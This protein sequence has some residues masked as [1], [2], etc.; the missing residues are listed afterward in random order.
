MLSDVREWLAEKPLVEYDGASGSGIEV[1]KTD[2]SLAGFLLKAAIENLYA[3]RMIDVLIDEAAD[4]WSQ[5]MMPSELELYPNPI[6]SE[7][8]RYQL[9]KRCPA[10]TNGIS[11]DVLNQLIE[12][13]RLR[14]KSEGIK[15]NTGLVAGT[16][17]RDRFNKRFET[18]R[19]PD[20]PTTL[21]SETRNPN[22]IPF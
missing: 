19:L 15:K 7:H 16:H 22:D 17:I 20:A 1:A 14:Y 11:A 18:R 6:D 8:V 13:G 9:K 5:E 12:Q 10:E 3:D 2:T 4:I 21:E